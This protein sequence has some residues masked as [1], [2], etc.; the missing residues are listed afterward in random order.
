LE[1]NGDSFNNEGSARSR[2]LYMTT[3][4]TL[5]RQIFM[6]PVGFEPAIP[7]SK[8]PQTHTFDRAATEIG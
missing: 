1:L 8:R 2:D 6:S 7:A 4:D 3:G 5:K